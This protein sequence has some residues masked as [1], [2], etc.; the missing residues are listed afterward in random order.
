MGVNP[1]KKALNVRRAS[2]GV[3]CLAILMRGANKKLLVFL[4]TFGTFSWGYDR[5]GFVTFRLVLW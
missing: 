3:A 2:F 5:G 4:R 1:L